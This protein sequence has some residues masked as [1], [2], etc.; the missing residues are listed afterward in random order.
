MSIRDVCRNVAREKNARTVQRFASKTTHQSN[1]FL[2]RQY[3]D[4]YEDLH[5]ATKQWFT[6]FSDI[7]SNSIRSSLR[8]ICAHKIHSE[9][10]WWTPFQYLFSA[11]YASALCVSGKSVFAVISNHE[12]KAAKVTNRAA[13]NNWWVRSLVCLVKYRSFR[14]K[15]A[16][17]TVWSRR[18]TCEARGTK[19]NFDVEMEFGTPVQLE[20]P[21]QE[22]SQTPPPYLD[23]ESEMRGQGV[24]TKAFRIRVFWSEVGRTPGCPACETPGLGKSHTRCV[25]GGLGQVA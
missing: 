12:V 18:E 14:R 23:R 17:R 24:H 21:R 11:P 16:W 3:T 2:L 20:P 4:T 5:D 1:V 15:T 10:R 22:A 13:G 9:T 6:A 25:E 8:W 19:W 7:S